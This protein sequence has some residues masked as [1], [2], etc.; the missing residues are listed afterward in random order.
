MTFEIPVGCE[1]EEKYWIRICNL[2]KYNYNQ[3]VPLLPH[4][5]YMYQ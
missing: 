2:E 5:T 1:K 4:Y 3:E